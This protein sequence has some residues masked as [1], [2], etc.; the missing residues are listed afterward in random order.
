MDLSLKLGILNIVL[1]ILFILLLSFIIYIYYKVIIKKDDYLSDATSPIKNLI[2][3]I[4]DI[5]KISNDINNTK[6][7]LLTP[8]SVTFDK[9]VEFKGKLKLGDNGKYFLTTDIIII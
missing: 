5:K 2:L 6:P 7:Y 1:F 8:S 9:D 3:S 4:N